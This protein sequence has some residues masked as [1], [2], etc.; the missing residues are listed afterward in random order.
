M[1]PVTQNNYGNRA[2]IKQLRLK[3]WRLLK[4][5]VPT[6]IPNADPQ[7]DLPGYRYAL[8]QRIQL[9]QAAH[10]DDG[11]LD[12][13]NATVDKKWTVVGEGSLEWA[14]ANAEHYGIE[15][16]TEEYWLEDHQTEEDDD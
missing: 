11:K 4:C 14:K 7:V 5:W 6:A 10:D 2:D 9:T 3:E 8:Q 13:D 1:N 15:V 12:W 16:P